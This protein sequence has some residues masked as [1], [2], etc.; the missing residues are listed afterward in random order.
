MSLALTLNEAVVEMEAEEG[1]R[2]AT[3]TGD[4]C[5][6]SGSDCTECIGTCVVVEVKLRFLIEL[7]CIYGLPANEQISS[8]PYDSTLHQTKTA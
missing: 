5:P 3:F 6:D 7:P 1:R 2:H 4:G 8:S